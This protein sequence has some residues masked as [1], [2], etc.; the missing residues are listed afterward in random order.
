MLDQKTFEQPHDKINKMACATSEASDQP[1]HPPSLIRVFAVLMKEAWV[2]SYHW[3][4]SEDSDQTRQMSRLIWVFA[5]RTVI[6]VV[7]SWGG[8]KDDG[9]F[10]VNVPLT[11][12][13]WKFIDSS[14]RLEEHRIELVTTWVARPAYQ[15]LR[16]DRSFQ[17][18]VVDNTEQEKPSRQDYFTHFEPSQS[19]VGAKM[20]DPREK[21][22]DHPQ[23]E[24]VWSHM[25]PR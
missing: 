17:N 4:H 22:P 8:S 16:H 15:P 10:W 19:Q 20:G 5:G 11:T 18:V 6:L 25:Y 7:L 24:L 12:R 9:G 2:L 21:P 3:A 14:K 1:G 13:S 23:A